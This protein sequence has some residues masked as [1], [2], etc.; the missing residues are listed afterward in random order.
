MHA[1]DGLPSYFTRIGYS[2]PAE[3]TLAVLRELH[4]RH[5]AQIA[6]EGLDPFLRR[7]VD[8]DP[9]AI[10]DK[11]LQRRRGGYCY[12]QNALFHDVLANLGFSVVALGARVVWMTPGRD[13][14]LTH[15][16]TLVELA[17]GRFLADVGFGGQTPTAP[18]SLEPGLAQVTPHGTYRVMRDGEG[19]ELQMRLP[20]R[21]E[22]MYRFTLTPHTRADFEVGNWFTATHP[23]TRFVRNL[24]AARVVGQDRVNLFN[25]SLAVR[26]PDGAVEQRMLA[27]AAE[28]R[29]VLEGEMGLELPVPAEE[30]WA[31]LP[32]QPVPSWP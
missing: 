19:F 14:P 5:P 21:W 22:A 15:R 13:A 10:E 3:P 17:E 9:A 16:L 6:F 31:R 26:R 8:I 2:G 24:V 29:D 4:L 18:L 30:I 27:G 25:A 23:R 28:L 20:E 12:E 32:S 7:P 1:L 11:L